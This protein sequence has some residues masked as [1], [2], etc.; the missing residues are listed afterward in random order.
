M[1]AVAIATTLLSLRL[2]GSRRGWGTALLAGVIGWGTATLVALGLNE[3][4]WGGDDLAVHLLAIGIPATMAAAVVLDLLA[5]PGSL[6]L[7]E[8]AG[9]IV[10]A[11]A[12]ARRSATDLGAAALSGAAAAVPGR[13]VRPVPVRRRTGRAVGRLTRCPRCAACLERAGGVYIKLGQIA[14]TRVDLIPREIC[15]ELAELQNRVQAVPKER[16]APVLEGELGAPVDEVFAEFDWEPLAAASIGQTYRARLRTGEAVVVKVQRPD[17]EELM[18]RD[19]AA[20]ALLADLAQRRTP[21]GQGLRTGEMLAQFARGLRAELDFRHEAD[22][23]T[24]MATAPRRVVDGAHP[25]GVPARL[26]PSG[27]RAGALRG[28]DVSEIRHLDGDVDRAGLADQ[29][30]RST[31]DQVMRIG[32]FHADPHPGNVFALPDGSLGL[33]DFGAVGRLDPIQQSAIVDVMVALTRRDVSLLRDGVERI[34]DLADTTSPEQLERAL[35]RVVAEHVRPGGG[36]D[37]AALEDLVAMLSRFGMRLPTDVVLLSRALVTVDGTLRS[38]RPDISLVTA[39]TE[40]LG[41]G[42]GPTPVVDREQLVRDEL[43]AMVP[44]L[45]RLPERVDRML[46]LAGRGELRVRTHRRRGQPARRCARSSTA[47]CSS[48]PGWPSSS[49]RRG[50]SSRRTTVHASP[51]RPACSRSSATAACSSAPCSCCASSPPS[52]GTGRYDT[53]HTAA[54]RTDV[55][56]ARE[57]DRRPPGERYYRHPGDVVRVVVWGVATVVLVLLIEVATGT[58]DGLRDDVGDAAALVPV[59]VRQMALGAAQVAAILVP[60]RDRPRARQPAPVAAIGRAARRGRRRRRRRGVARPRRRTAR[61]HRRGARRRLLVGPDE[62]PVARVPGRRGRRDH[63]QQAVAGPGVAAHRRPWPP[64]AD[65]SRWRSPGRAGLA[66]LLL[67]TSA[68]ILAGAVVLVVVGAPNRRPS[69]MAVATALGEAGLE[70]TDLALERAV[71]GRAQLYRAALADGTSSFVKVYARDSRDADLLYRGYRTALFREP[72]EDWPASSL[73][74]DVEH[75][76]LALLLARRDG[77]RCP[78]LRAVTVPAR[79]LDGRGDGGHPRPAARHHRAGRADARAAGRGVAAGGRHCTPPASPTGAFRA[80]NVVVAG[81][82]PVIVDLGATRSPATPR[83]QAIDR[84]ELLASLAA[85]VGPER[86]DRVGRPCPRPDGAGRRVAGTCSRWRSRR[87]RASRCPKATLKQLRDGIA[88]ATGLEPEPLERLVRVRPRTIVMI[89]TLAG[90]FYFL[91]P[92]LANVD[93]SVHALRVGELGM[94]RRHGRA[95]RGSR[96]SRP[97]SGWLA[98][99]PCGCRSYRRCTP[100]WR[101]RSSTG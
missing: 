100:S 55:G 5:R 62:L 40:L 50:C 92:Q 7:G 19:L 14:A 24:E 23:M 76:G 68:G 89:A 27:A 17:I 77:V 91:L 96:T 56:A 15:D 11:A 38:L 12:A 90:A 32:L 65:R 79:R 42:A 20:L 64:A 69:P 28:Q 84:A 75:E 67:A 98:A 43:L 46:T 35:A 10:D 13:R 31:L 83:L 30:L 34:A 3:W 59:A 53:D 37:P 63:G 2:L 22:A 6:A 41:D 44:H 60:G 72:T 73:E 86:G 45:R 47:C 97:R 58:N 57:F 61:H 29:L 70:V 52:R 101:L 36:V 8:R 81:D 94:A 78:D 48:S 39:A 74:R 80:A 51:A 85:L 66:E 1:L 4:E 18:E 82:R 9:L 25:Q 93:D 95:V 71:G 87:R 33:I 26:R 99:C 21:F 16:I 54:R 49:P 88:A